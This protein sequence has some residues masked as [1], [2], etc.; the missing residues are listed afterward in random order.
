MKKNS[1]RNFQKLKVSMNPETFQ[2]RTSLHLFMNHFTK[3]ITFE[4]YM[5]FFNC[6]SNLWA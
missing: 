3:V 2:P 6:F 5:A 4:D 1:T